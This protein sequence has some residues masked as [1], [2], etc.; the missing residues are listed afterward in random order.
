[1][2]VSSS[3]EGSGNTDDSEFEC[4]ETLL[5]AM[6]SGPANLYPQDLKDEL[7]STLVNSFTVSQHLNQ[8]KQVWIALSFQSV[9]PTKLT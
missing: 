7:A 9:K 3:S 4:L 2:N 5:D 1:M 8:I 6:H